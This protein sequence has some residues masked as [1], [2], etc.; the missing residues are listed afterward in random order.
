MFTT[1][2]SPRE[3]KDRKPASTPEPDEMPE[4][5]DKGESAAIP[6]V[7]E[8]P[9]SPVYV[10]LWNNPVTMLGLFVVVVSM[11]LLLT[12]GLFSIISP[13]PNP[14]VDIVGYL[15]I[16]GFLATGVGLTP[17]GIL[18]KS[19]WLRKRDP[20]QRLAFRFPRVDLNDP[21]QRRAAKYF[22]GGTFV[23]LPVVGVTSYHGY[24]FTDSTE[25]CAQA[26]HSVM[27]PQAVAFKESPHARVTC[28]ECH[29]GSG[30]SWFVKSKLSG[31]RQVLAMWNKSYSRPI[32]P[33]ISELRPA[34]D[35]CE[36]CHWPQKFFGTQLK[37]VVRYA[38]DEA[39]TPTEVS[40]LLKIGGGDESTGKPEGIHFHMALA[41]AIQYVAVDETL[42]HIPW[43]KWVDV[44]GDEWIFR[45]D[46][47]PSSDPLP[48]GHLRSLD[49]MDCHNR[50]AHKFRAPSDAV[51][52]QLAIGRIDTTLPFIKREAVA[53]L[54]EPYPDRE[55]GE[56]KIGKEIIDFY[57]QKYPE[58]WSDR[59]A[60]VKLA[61]DRVRE[62]YRR[63][64][65]PSMD[66]DWRTY[67]DNIGHKYSAG[68]FRCH[69]GKH[70]DQRGR[71]IRTDCN[72]CHTFLNPL[73]NK[74]N[75]TIIEEGGFV[76]PMTLPSQHEDIQ[77]HKCHTGGRAMK[78]SCEGCHDQQSSFIAATGPVW[79]FMKIEPSSMAGVVDCEG[80]HDLSEPVSRESV[81]TA[82]MECHED[83]DDTY[84]G[85]LDN[86]HV[87]VERKRKMA[88]AALAE[89]VS[90][91]GS[92]EIDDVERW[93]RD[94]QSSL[95]AV[96]QAGPL[97]NYAA[98][99]LVYSGIKSEA[100]VWKKKLP[101]MIASLAEGDAL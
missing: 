71:V 76:H 74:D 3:M 100:G 49:C 35:T 17:F 21:K 30:A 63:N 27:E 77:C 85:M 89:L 7:E 97:H 8:A 1:S 92:H 31:T 34:R 6:K 26:C 101:A 4:P 69:D 64:M 95:D 38:S 72:M 24:H 20:T 96:S 90:A 16:P 83:E 32:E 51:D 36:Q 18:L 46:G 2:Q 86:W 93:V 81:D 9:Y 43:V 59:K 48:E 5:A 94:A 66:V 70:V 40:V 65:F 13:S 39:N 12:F 99:I 45:S 60:S 80:C 79:S 68:C 14:Y 19:W 53:V 73:A 91:L 56:A 82:C 54:S 25:F 44:A 87:D 22:I 50:P 47:K 62:I 75:K 33:A 10:P 55:T 61:V 23:L 67:P 29:I 84:E 11:I 15:I 78:T 41:G 88:E 42:Q 52:I 58:V 37:Q 28:A 98:A 57:K